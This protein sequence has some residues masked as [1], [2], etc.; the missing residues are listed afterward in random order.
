MG[1]ELLN[2]PSMG[3]SMFSQAH[4]ND[5][6]STL[7]YGAYSQTL[8]SPK[9]ASFQALLSGEDSPFQS[10]DDKDMSYYQFDA[11]SS[12]LQAPI[13]LPPTTE[14][15]DAYE[16]PRTL[17]PAMGR[18][19]LSIPTTMYQQ[20]MDYS[21][22]SA[23]VPSASH[24]ASSAASSVNGSPYCTPVE[25]WTQMDNSYPQHQWELDPEAYIN[26][27]ILPSN[28]YSRSAS[29]ASPTIRRNGKI[30]SHPRQQSPHHQPYPTSRPTSVH[31]GSACSSPAASTLVDRKS[32]V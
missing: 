19:Y 1:T 15:Y 30:S 11:T 10:Q 27:T 24:T 6:D 26:P 8:S 9:E 13:S 21:P 32:V 2:N 23:T 22:T 16:V 31:D 20:S 17:S 3:S 12:F 14:S 18:H 4:Y 25:L 7:L 28:V 5:S 29:P